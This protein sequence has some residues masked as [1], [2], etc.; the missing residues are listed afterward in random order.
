MSGAR[1]CRTSRPTIF[2]QQRRS[3]PAAGGELEQTQLLP[4]HSSI[5]T[6]ERHLG[7]KQYPANAPND[8][9]KLKLA[10]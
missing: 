2:D 10:L 9:I 5:Q 7:T 8:A 1:A 6:T 4:G 3:C